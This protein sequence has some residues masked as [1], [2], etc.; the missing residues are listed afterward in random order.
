M[1]PLAEMQRAVVHDGSVA[2]VPLAHRTLEA[3]VYSHGISMVNVPPSPEGQ[4]GTSLFYYVPMMELVTGCDRNTTQ[5]L[6][7]L[8]VMI[9]APKMRGLVATV[10]T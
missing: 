9:C 4:G 8:E 1:P 3:S 6:L 7:A 2:G 5:L 10:A